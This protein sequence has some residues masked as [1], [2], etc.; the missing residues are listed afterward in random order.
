LNRRGVYR[1]VYSVLVDDPDFRR[2]SSAA[3]HGLLTM[4]ASKEIGIACLWLLEPVTLAKR[5]GY[6]LDETEAILA[7]LS[8]SPSPDGPWIYRDGD[9]T[10]LRNGLRYDPTTNLTNKAHLSGVLRAISSLPHSSLIGKFC[11]YYGIRGPRQDLR[12]TST[13]PPKDLDRTL[14]GLRIPRPRP[15]PK[16]TEED[17]DRTRARDPEPTRPVALATGLQPSSTARPLAEI[18][19]AEMV[20]THHQSAAERVAALKR[21][22]GKA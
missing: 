15:R 5:T 11:R 13:G 8:T 10:W 4:R 1:S 3:R 18:I 9:L 21:A 2:L 12:R 6:T 16:K 17:R 22:E 20:M 19:D 14:T 7:E